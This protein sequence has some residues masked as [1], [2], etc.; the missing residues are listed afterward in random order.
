MKVY[1]TMQ[2][3]VCQGNALQIT[4]RVRNL[5]DI[6]PRTTPDDVVALLRKSG[7]E[8]SVTAAGVL[9]AA[10]KAG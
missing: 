5:L 8:I 1:G 10:I 7:A 4:E 2:S 6:K 3:V 9:L